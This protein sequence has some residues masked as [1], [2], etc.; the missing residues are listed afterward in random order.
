MKSK[1]AIKIRMGAALT[2][3]LLVVAVVVFSGYFGDH[4]QS[5]FD[6]EFSDIKVENPKP[7]LLSSHV[8][9]IDPGESVTVCVTVQ[10]NGEEIIYRDAYGVG[11]EVVYPKEGAK[12]WKL[13][14][15]R[16]MVI[17]M[18]PGGRSSYTFNAWNR[19]EKPFTGNFKIHAYIRSIQTGNK[20]AWSENVTVVLKPPQ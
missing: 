16:L 5:E 15:E 1:T 8:V 12:Y 17:D 3:L 20:L 4:D 11:I 14:A 18:G 9:T 13:P 10:N 6:L 7:S 2:I 19:K